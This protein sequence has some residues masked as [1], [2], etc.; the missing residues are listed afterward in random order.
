MAYKEVAGQN[1]GKNIEEDNREKEKHRKEK[2]RGLFL[3]L[4]ENIVRDQN[5]KQRMA[6]FWNN[7]VEMEK[8][9]P[10]Y[11]LNMGDDER[12]EKRTSKRLELE[13][14][15][16]QEDYF[17]KYFLKAWDDG[18]TEVDDEQDVII[19]ISD[20]IE[21]VLQ[22]ARADLTVG[23]FEMFN[24]FDNEPDKESISIRKKIVS[25]LKELFTPFFGVNRQRHY[26]MGETLKNMKKE[27]VELN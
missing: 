24:S 22:V 16:N 13:K 1:T 11:I 26:A 5:F 9:V 6:S 10:Y 8:E 19:D 7:M 2:Y 4:V 12:K 15:F 23:L 27:T 21:A 20:Q 3:D 17:I 25:G 18:P 14:I